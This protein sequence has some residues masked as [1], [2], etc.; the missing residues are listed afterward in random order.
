PAKVYGISSGSVYPGKVQDR[1]D[2]NSGHE[3]RKVPATRD[4]ALASK[5]ECFLHFSDHAAWGLV[6]TNSVLAVATIALLV[7]PAM[8]PQQVGTQSQSI[9][10]RV[11]PVDAL[12][13]LIVWI[14]FQNGTHQSR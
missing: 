11:A 10:F 14:T 7:V 1:D 5:R 12:S 8:Q 13:K 6:V 4:P 2:S 3:S 9:T